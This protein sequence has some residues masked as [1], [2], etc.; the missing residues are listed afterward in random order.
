MLVVSHDERPVG[1]AATRNE[2]ATKQ[3]RGGKKRRRHSHHITESK[4]A[5]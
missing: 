5:T 4:E 1:I 2:K 3:R